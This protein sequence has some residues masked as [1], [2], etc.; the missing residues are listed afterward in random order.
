MTDT[1]ITEIRS[2]G[3]SYASSAIEDIG[4]VV[5]NS[6]GKDGK[7]RCRMFP[8]C[9]NELNKNALTKD[10]KGLEVGKA[11]AAQV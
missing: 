2:L 11:T 1:A 6:C 4:R 8:K 9:T 5:R 10:G 7:I 3:G